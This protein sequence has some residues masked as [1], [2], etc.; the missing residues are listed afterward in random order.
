MDEE[1]LPYTFKIVHQDMVNDTVAEFRREYLAQLG[2][3]GEKADRTS[4]AVGAGCQFFP[5]DL[6]VLLLTVFKGKSACG[7][8]LVPSAEEI[9]TVDVLRGEQ[10]VET[11]SGTI[12]QTE[13]VVVLVVDVLVAV[14]GVEVPGVARRSRILRARP[15]PNQQSCPPTS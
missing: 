7:I 8:S 13:V 4:G 3:F 5:D 10:H 1:R 15:V 12:C 14:V 11:L 2:A 9:L 6:E